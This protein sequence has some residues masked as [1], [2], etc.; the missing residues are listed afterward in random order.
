[1]AHVTVSEDPC[2]LS[3]PPPS[4][5]VADSGNHEACHSQGRVI[6]LLM[7]V[8][9][10]IRFLYKNRLVRLFALAWHNIF[11]NSK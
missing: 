10:C 7:A 4:V 5:G 2:C 8:N 11:L 6:E 1:M 3:G 9:Q